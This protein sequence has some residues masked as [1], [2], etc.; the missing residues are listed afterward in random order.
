MCRGTPRDDGAPSF[1][2]QQDC[3]VSVRVYLSVLH[4]LS[5]G[6]R[7]RIP[8]VRLATIPLLAPVYVG[9]LF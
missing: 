6:L 4:S 2:S 5:E 8:T 1:R 9:T 7:F 3:D